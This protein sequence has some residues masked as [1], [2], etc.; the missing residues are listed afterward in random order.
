MPTPKKDDFPHAVSSLYLSK[1]ISRSLSSL[2]GMKGEGCPC[3]S[4]GRWDLPIVVDWLESRANAKM[5][6]LSDE[7]KLGE[8]KKL[9][10]EAQ[11]REIELEK[12]RS[13]SIPRAEYESALIERAKHNRAV[14][15]YEC[16]AFASEIVGTDSLADGMNR[17]RALASSILARLRGKK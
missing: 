11:R 5:S 9:S 4:D 7:K 14:I 17:M 12:L 2:T 13:E 6:N 10:L 16:S 1:A 8:I 3:L 15:D